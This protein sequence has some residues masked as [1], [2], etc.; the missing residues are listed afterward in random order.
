MPRCGSVSDATRRAV[1][2]P[3]RNLELVFGKLE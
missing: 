3:V 1:Q 2:F